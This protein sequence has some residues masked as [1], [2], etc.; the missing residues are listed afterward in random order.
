[1]LM[2]LI[3]LYL[4]SWFAWEGVLSIPSTINNYRKDSLWNT[5]ALTTLCEEVKDKVPKDTLAFGVGIPELY[6]QLGWDS[7]IPAID[8]TWQDVSP[9]AFS[10]AESAVSQSDSY[11]TTDGTDFTDDDF[12][13]VDQIGNV[14]FTLNYYKR[15]KN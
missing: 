4:V 9:D 15:V 2:S 5:E 12:V 11:I 10:L 3:S 14:S 1:M 7:Q 8:W 13:L 6:Y